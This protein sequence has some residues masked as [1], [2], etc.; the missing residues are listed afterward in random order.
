MYSIDTD[1]QKTKK[2]AISVYKKMKE[3]E[4]VIIVLCGVSVGLSIYSKQPT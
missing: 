2:A 4:F 1:R 3:E